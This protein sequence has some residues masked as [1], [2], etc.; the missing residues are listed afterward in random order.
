MKLIVKVHL[1]FLLVFADRTV[2]AGLHPR[3]L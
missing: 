1:V 2:V 3:D